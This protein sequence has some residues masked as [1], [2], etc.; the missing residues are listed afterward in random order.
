MSTPW[1]L[2]PVVG[3]VTVP[4]QVAGM[5]DH[6][7]LGTGW[8]DK[9]VHDDIIIVII[10]KVYQSWIFTS[11]NMLMKHTFPGEV[12]SFTVLLQASIVISFSLFIGSKNFFSDETC[13]RPE[14]NSS[15]ARCP[16]ISAWR[17]WTSISANTGAPYV[18]EY[19]RSLSMVVNGSVK[20]FMAV[21]VRWTVHSCWFRMDGGRDIYQPWDSLDHLAYHICPEDSYS[22]ILSVHELTW[23]DTTVG[24]Q[25]NC[26]RSRANHLLNELTIWLTKSSNYW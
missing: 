26:W 15:L 12:V 7:V 10:K 21:T 1:P 23:C 25:R 17:T 11:W 13:R 8:A 24:M 20:L 18:M 14:I 6:S 4:S 2:Y 5:L 22:L 9:H 3:L 19:N 16:R